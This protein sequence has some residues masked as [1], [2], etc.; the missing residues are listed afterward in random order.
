MANYEVEFE[1]RVYDE[2]IK[3]G[4]PKSSIIMGGQIS[5]K[6]SVGSLR[7]PNGMYVVDFLINDV[8]TGLPM[9]IIEVKTAIKSRYADALQRA[10]KN[11]RLFSAETTLPVKA[12]AAIFGH[13]NQLSFVDFTEAISSGDYDLAVDDY[14]LPSYEMLTSG[15]KHKAIKKQQKEQKRRINALKWL[16]WGI[17]PFI[18][19][20]L[21]VVDA[22]GWYELSAL[23]LI[24][25]GV[26]AAA[27]LIPCFKVISIGELTLKNIIEKQNEESE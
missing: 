25:I 24:T 23:R 12:V 8:S 10:Y 21:I 3:K 13:D 22:H 6:R 5:E 19:L 16:C 4:Y 26:G 15:A 2:L 9:M 27:P 14:P 11:L 17:I 1:K 7:A 20:T 18:A